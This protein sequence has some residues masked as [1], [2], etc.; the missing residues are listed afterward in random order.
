MR[1]ALWL[2]HVR[3][4]IFDV[5]GTLIDSNDAHVQAWAAALRTHRLPADANEIARLIGM[6]SD[7]VIAAL[8]HVDESSSLGQSI[9]RE[10][11][12]VFAARLPSLQAMPGARALLEYLRG[13]GITL[14]VATSA[15]DAEVQA[16][17]KQAGIA[18]LLADRTSKDDAAESKPAADIVESALAR[19]GAEAATSVMVGDT[20]YDIEAARRA[21]IPSIALRCGRFWTDADLAGARVI[22][23]D[24][25]DMLAFWREQSQ[26]KVRVP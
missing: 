25:A 12:E 13:R 8:A 4:A 5:D 9:A 1:D 19:V 18:D 24:P 14:T 11:R 3:T 26:E 2:R 10:K 22:R 15:G 7:K 17:V 16:L 6:G 20:P 21:G 23:D